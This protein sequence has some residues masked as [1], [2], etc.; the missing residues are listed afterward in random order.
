MKYSTSTLKYYLAG[1]AIFVA[2]SASSVC[3]YTQKKFIIA[4]WF[5][6]E[7]YGYDPVLAAAVSQARPLASWDAN[8]DENALRKVKELGFNT[9]LGKTYDA[10][11]CRHQVW[12]PAMIE[13][14]LRLL[15]RVGGLTMFVD[16]ARLANRGD[17][18]PL[19]ASVSS[20]L[21]DYSNMPNQIDNLI[22]G[23][24][25]KDEPDVNQAELYGKTIDTIQS[26]AKQ[27]TG[28]TTLYQFGGPM[29]AD[30]STGEYY[31]DLYKNYVDSY[32]KSR[33]YFV[34]FDNY[35]L[36]CDVVNCADFAMVKNYYK[37]YS[38]VAKAAKQNGSTLIGFALS[39]GFKMYKTATAPDLGSPYTYPPATNYQ[40]TPARLNFQAFL[41]IAYGAKGIAWFTY[42]P[43]ICSAPT[44]SSYNIGENFSDRAFI[45]LNRNVSQIGLDGKRI[46]DFLASIGSELILLDWQRT[47]HSSSVN[48]MRTWGGVANSTLE[49]PESNLETL[50]P[51][52]PFI[53]ELPN[54]NPYF[55]IGCYA[56]SG[57]PTIL[58]IVNK[59][60]DLPRTL[61][62]RFKNEVGVI[63]V[64]KFPNMNW[65]RISIPRGR[66]IDILLPPG[67]IAF[68]EVKK[69]CGYSCQLP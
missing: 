16:D 36:Y 4:T 62:I 26:L 7:L 31:E 60:L 59:D 9:L 21:A 10:I 57:R 43:P 1:I 38:I 39:S 27:M 5:D 52:F 67:E 35:G 29:F 51:T 15:Q 54:S 56:K 12:T 33:P 25:L 20:V 69:G 32:L 53:A 42:S 63:R 65:Q 47:I 50:D 11:L 45:D 44:S 19:T 6:P 64:R 23:F 14:K 66:I 13:Y 30:G 49:P 3:A 68:L 22:E 48:N 17:V 8:S 18:S 46:N 24:F 37:N 55:V 41:P 40:M 34:P 61:K 28:W 2:F 58:A